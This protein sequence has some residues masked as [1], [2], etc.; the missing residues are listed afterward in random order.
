MLKIIQGQQIKDLDHSYISLSKMNSIDLMERAANTF[1]DWFVSKNY[2]K[3][4]IIAVFCGAG[5]NGG[6]GFAISRILTE[7]GYSVSVINCFDSDEKLSPDSS[8]NRDRLQKSIEISNWKGYTGSPEII[9]DAF[10]GVGLRGELRPKAVQIIQKIND[11][12][13][14]VISVDIPSGLASEG[15]HENLVVQADYTFTF[16]IPKLSLLIPENENCVGELILGDIGISEEAF[17]E[18][19]SSVYYLEKSDIAPLHKVFG[20][21]SHKGSF[22]KNLILGGSQGK[23]GALVLA[24]KS[25]LRTGAGLVTCHM[26]E[27]ERFILQ[28][29]LPEAMATW[30]ILANLE[31][32]DAIGIGPGWGLE[33][34]K[35]LLQHVFDRYLG[36]LVLDADAL[37]LLSKYPE[38]LK[39]IPKNSILTPHIGEFERLVGPS[40]NHFGR[41]EKAKLI[42]KKYNIVLILKGAHTV[43]SLPDGRQIFNSSGNQYMATGGSGD[44]LTGM[45]TAFLGM[46][47]SPENAA[48]CGVYHHGLA[49]E[50]ASKSKRRSLIASDIVEVIPD[51]YLALNIS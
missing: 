40:I 12:H 26:E 6:D 42:A 30:G 28:I 36:G 27:S 9:I 22:G 3:N 33:N 50:I 16:A 4:K 48:I 7:L 44:V 41:L 45:I 29:Y 21:F 49:G 11:N 35:E 10:L 17:E 25:C 51:S 1:C 47:Y 23:M 24:A 46:G 14:F 39:T 34:R 37:N 38:L 2:D 43:I 19:D 13:G 5:N 8:I 20:K 15:V 18:F 31:S 32:Y